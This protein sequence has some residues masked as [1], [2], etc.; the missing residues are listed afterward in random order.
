MQGD[1]KGILG[2][3]S[4]IS[5][6]KAAISRY[7]EKYLHGRQNVIIAS[8]ETC[9]KSRMFFSVFSEGLLKSI[10]NNMGTR[11]EFQITEGSSPAFAFNIKHFRGNRS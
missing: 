5:I 7:S 2:R 1:Q 11:I 3:K 10:Y 9:I 4:L 8:N 6:K